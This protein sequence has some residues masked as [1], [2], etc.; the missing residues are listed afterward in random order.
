VGESE[1]IVADLAWANLVITEYSTVAVEALALGLPV[2]S[3][4]LS[5][6]PP[7]LDFSVPGQAES[8][9]R[10]SGISASVARLLAGAG[11]ADTTARR[12]ALLEELVGPLDGSSAA[13]VAEI[14]GGL[15]QQP[16]PA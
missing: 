7:V 6:R 8:V 4:T 10:K 14:V 16:V 1:D 13:R 9:D 5:G 15:L 11:G 3:V 12:G 2:L